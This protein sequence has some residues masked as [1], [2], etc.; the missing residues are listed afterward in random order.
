[1]TTNNIFFVDSRVADYQRLIAA[2]PADSKAFLLNPNQDGIEQMRMILSNYS[3][4]DSVQVISHGTQ[5]ALYLGNIV[6][7]RSN[8]DQY[9]SELGE[10]GSRLTAD[11]DLLLYGCDVAQ[12]E[13][14]RQFIDRLAQLTGADVAASE[15][16][17]GNAALGGNWE[18]ESRIGLIETV[19]QTLK[20]DGLLGLTVSPNIRSFP[21]HTLGEFGNLLAFAALK[22]D[23][24]V[25]TWGD[26][27][28]GGDSSGVASKL[29]NVKQIYSNRSA[30]AALKEDGTVVAWGHPNFGG[31]DSPSV[32]S[33]LVNVKQIYSTG[34]AFAA[35]REDGTVVA[36][37]YTLAGG[38]DSY[39]GDTISSEA[40]HLLNVKQIFSTGSAFAALTEDGT[41]V[42]W[43]SWF[44]GGNTRGHT[45]ELVDVTQIYSTGSA[46]AALKA[47]GSVV[48]WGDLDHGGDS[49]G[50]ASELVNV[51]QIYSTYLAF[52][53]L[54]QD[55]TVITWGDLDNGGDSSGVADDLV[56]VTQIYSSSRAFAAL[57]ADGSVVTWGELSDGGDSSGVADDLVDVTQIYSNPYAFAALKADGSVITWGFADSG[58]DSSGVADD[59]VDVT[60]IYSTPRAFAALKAD[61]SVVTWGDV[62]RGGDSS[63]VADKLTS[64]VVSFANIYTDDFYTSTPTTILDTRINT[65]TA[66]YQSDPSMVALSNGDFVVTWRSDFQD[67]S[68]WGIYGQRYDANGN[69]QGDEFRVNTYTAGSQSEN[70]VAALTNDGFVVTWNSRNQ[71]GSDWGV[72]GQLYDSS[73]NA[74]GT[75][76]RINTNTA[77]IQA[78]SSVAALADGGFVVTWDSYNQDGSNGGVYA[79]RYD[80]NGGT[81]GTEFRVNSYTTNNQVLSSVAALTDGGFVVT[82]QSYSQDGA[83][84]GIYGQ[85]YDA[86]GNTQGA[87]FRVNSHT[88]SD[89][90][91][92]SVTALTNGGFVVTWGSLGQDGSGYGIY[93]QRYDAS[94][95]TAGGEFLINSYTTNNQENPWVTALSDGGFVVFWESL[96][97]D[98]SGDG[99]Y[100]QRYN[101][102]GIAQGG[103]FLVNT[104][105]ADTQIVP[106]ATGLADGGFAVTWMSF[107]QDG[108][109]T[110][111]FGKRYDANGNEVEWI[112]SYSNDKY[113]ITPSAPV[114]SEAD[115]KIE[116][117]ITRP[118]DRLGIAETVYVSTTRNHG[119]DNVGDYTG[120]E[121]KPY[122]FGVG[123]KTSTPI[124]VNILHDSI[125]EP[126]ET[127]GL[128][129]QTNPT[130][131]LTTYLASTTFTI[132]DS[133][134][135]PPGEWR[136]TP[137][138]IVASE[139]DGKI[140]FTITRPD[141]HLDIAET[142]YIS[143]NGIDGSSN[144]GDFI[145][146]DPTYTF[147]VGEK[148]SAPIAIH[149]LSDILVEDDETF[150]LIVK[151]P[152]KTPLA[153]TNFTISDSA[154]EPPGSEIDSG[155]LRLAFLSD[156]Q[157]WIKLPDSDTWTATGDMI[158]GLAGSDNDL[159]RLEG[160]D[161][162][163]TR[164]AFYATDVTVYSIADG[165]EKALF[166]GNFDLSLNKPAGTINATDNILDLGGV[167]FKYTSLEL[168]FDTIRLGN[169]FTLPADFSETIPVKV[170]G[171]PVVIDETGIALSQ[172]SS[173]FSSLS[174]FKLLNYINIKPTF[175]EITYDQDEDKLLI[176]GELN[177]SEEGF[178]PEEVDTAVKGN[179]A[180]QNGA[181][182]DLL[183][184]LE[185]KEILGFNGY[186]IKDLILS[187]D[188]AKNEIKSGLTVLLP[189][190]NPYNRADSELFK[191]YVSFE[192]YYRY[193]SSP[194]FEDW[195]IGALAD[196][197]I[198]P[199][200]L[201]GIRGSFSIPREVAIPLG[202]T[203]L[204]VT[205]FSGGVHNFAPTNPEPWTV[206]GSISLEH[207]LDNFLKFN[208]VGELN[209]ESITG[210]VDGNFLGEGKVDF[211]AE[212]DIDWKEESA[213]L[214]DAHVSFFNNLLNAEIDI[215]TDTS[216][217]TIIAR[218]S[219]KFN[220]LD[221]GISISGNAYLNIE[222]NDNESDD[223]AKVW[224]ESH[225][226]FPG[227]DKMLVKG[228]KVS[229]HDGDWEYFGAKDVPIYSSW[230]V[231]SSMSDLIVTVDWQNEAV[232]PVHTRVVVYDD[233][234]KTKVRE[235]I[236]ESDYLTHGIA[237]VDEW[238]GL[239]NKVIYISKPEAGLWDVEVVDP[240]GLGDINYSATTSLAE[241][242]FDLGAA[243]A[244]GNLIQIGYNLDN[245]MAGTRLTVFADT[246]GDGYDGT[247]IGAMT[248]DATSGLFTWNSSGFSA[249]QYWLY[250]VL[251][252]DERIPLF[253]YANNPIDVV[254]Q[255]MG[256]L[257]DDVL[258]GTPG[259]DI[260]MFGLAG[261]DTLE[262]R[263]GDDALNG[264]EGKDILVGGK[265]VDILTGGAGKDSFKDNVAGLIGDT[266]TDFSESDVIHIDGVRLVDESDV[267]YD[268]VSG[269]LALDSQEGNSIFINL[270]IGL[271]PA[272]IYSRVS[273]SEDKPWTEIF[274]PSTENSAPELTGT[275][276]ALTDGIE[277]INYIVNA[278]AL[279][280]GWTDVEGDLLNITSLTADHG[281][282]IDN[283]DGTYTIVPEA[284]YNGAMT[285]KYGVSDGADT[286]ATTLAFVLA[287][288]D[289]TPR[290]GDDYGAAN[291]DS[292]VTVSF[293][294]LMINDIDV[295]GASKTIIGIDTTGTAGSV[296][297]DTV[298][299]TMTYSADAD[300]F[301][302]LATGATAK[303][304]FKYIL[305]G[306]SGETNT[307]TVFMD[308]IGVNDETEISGTIRSETLNG[309]AG[310]DRIRGNDGNDVLKGGAGN[311]WLAGERGS[312]ILFGGLGKDVFFF[313]KGGSGDTISDFTNGFDK[314]QIAADTGIT[315]FG[316]LKIA[317]G[318]GKGFVYTTFSLGNDTQVVLNGVPSTVL[319]ATDF[320]FTA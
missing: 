11:G 22:A 59:L 90:L 224:W 91:W 152:F 149:I 221:I 97:Q 156:A 263:N 119:S 168:I 316:Q 68:D 242:T 105:T 208:I 261:N 106:S 145:G 1:M 131:P 44:G 227:F 233:L 223:Y 301:D 63:S 55:G 83:E 212:A 127:F 160:G 269:L 23:G 177:I 151:D 30:F 133:V 300:A 111:I 26:S 140:E 250:G 33:K 191:T 123:D 240:D 218:G 21:G 79:Q 6:L 181:V 286:T 293:D 266:I 298:N 188:T 216:F 39:G 19:S 66:S 282:A 277:D 202:Y 62:G 50:V 117:T 254:A 320:I 2:L 318:G 193:S 14:G 207:I 43:G 108:S 219:A 178:F 16:L 197:Q 4:L 165:T 31:T 190:T 244:S 153:E 170:A 61:G 302:L 24:S 299:R 251:E 200:K 275:V 166:S 58:G 234:A 72:Y 232:N 157:R 107:N 243:S 60:Q 57:K 5:G 7:T 307:A 195:A 18:L 239:K 260:T 315:S 210:S 265:G 20:Y 247:P 101:A 241:N 236:N 311:D 306:S 141:D 35:L 104:H 116:F 159:L 309:T 294:D 245:L 142:V 135:T 182:S 276:V 285:L 10:I 296:V 100:G 186:G 228:V 94:G 217:N 121:N 222:N 313:S 229:L 280:T 246:D 103:E 92:P 274:G 99:I 139:A 226:S 115:G 185:V 287:P 52:A 292:S 162:V 34:E 278:S 180:I 124:T 256:T 206:R 215:K 291:E 45:D 134:V 161:Y 126:D 230:I 172:V 214:K 102:S 82:W 164:D 40:S 118:D 279:L 85:R 51:K 248:I 25:V 176:G 252:D 205:G 37:G 73:G 12:G 192:D 89:Q 314:I 113:Q 46:F 213:E 8:I 49:S 203:S 112:G 289:D 48:T 13:I 231:D 295:D 86:S 273:S 80:I 138:D 283:L 189:L 41:V 69:A 317:G 27:S 305:Q 271:D 128:I 150:G 272:L 267:H 143:T 144:D 238:S 32:I 109:A 319:D 204:L 148:T 259:D 196:F 297:I 96:S 17:T 173:T 155:D 84:W 211:S 87:E 174:A 78:N 312:D 201:D 93:G 125:A 175:L 129:V 199:F 81:V 71:D 56:D 237:V 67:G 253:D 136:I 38:S 15:D 288:V 187:I 29:V 303:D 53:A 146:P 194:P 209:S 268:P 262:G 264:G 54:K 183:V 220:P 308:V 122:T 304:S 36:W 270:P 225:V 167:D 130:D 114:V 154:A 284:N 3:E 64:E 257:N 255:L 65:Y 163:I 171:V 95:N 76:F 74:Q 147:D 290:P 110:G 132:Q 75:E 47:D 198:S 249:G 184:S 70:T 235:I 77:D 98:G 158:V 169:E 137:D 281:I 28:Y 88:A 310:D 120:L 258:I 179:I 9:R 42:A